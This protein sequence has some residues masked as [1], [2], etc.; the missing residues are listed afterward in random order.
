MSKLITWGLAHWQG[1]LIKLGH[2]AYEHKSNLGRVIGLHR[3]KVDVVTDRG[4]ESLL[5][6]KGPSQ[7]QD[8][9]PTVGDWIQFSDHTLGEPSIDAV[10][11]RTSILSR[12]AS[13]PKH[14][15][16]ELAANLDQVFILS[17]MDRTFSVARIERFLVACW[18]NNLQ[19]VLVLTRADLVATSD[20]FISALNDVAIDTPIITI[21]ALSLELIDSLSDFLKPGQTTTLLGTSGAGKSSLTNTLAGSE[22]MATQ[23]VRAFDDK[24]RHTTTRRQLILLPDDRGLLI[25]SPGVR[26]MQIWH[27]LNWEQTSFHDILLEGEQCK[28]SDC[29]HDTEQLCAVQTRA[30]K[31]EGFGVLFRK[32][33]AIHRV[34]SGN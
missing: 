12:R 28:F 32:Y 30:R 14:Q 33:Q 19:P 18:L 31:D 26:E 23:S 29:Q 16:Q 10:L 7:T 1:R 4:L 5:L 2:G 27:D 13:G 24:G 9:K 22:I 17:A 21:N 11:P 15:I 3:Q 25:D 8:L 34:I 20:P 6:K